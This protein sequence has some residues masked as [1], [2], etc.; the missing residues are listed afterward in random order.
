MA[1]HMGVD[2]ITIKNL[3]IVGIDKEKNL[4]YLNGAVPGIRRTILEIKSK[5]L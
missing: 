2:R 3:K 4:M 1:G 5:A